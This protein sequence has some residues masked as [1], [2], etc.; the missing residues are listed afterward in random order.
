M[1]VEDRLVAVIVFAV[2]GVSHVPTSTSR[3]QLGCA[4]QNI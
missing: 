2:G 4:A 3:I 1:L